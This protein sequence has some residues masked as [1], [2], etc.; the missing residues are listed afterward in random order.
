M[1]GLLVHETLGMIVVLFLMHEM[2]LYLLHGFW[3]LSLLTRTRIAAAVAD[4]HFHTLLA[5]TIGTNLGAR[6]WLW[7][8]GWASAAHASRRPEHDVFKVIHLRQPC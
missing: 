5:M 4:W 8:S 1:L 7:P 3:E 2:V 6:A